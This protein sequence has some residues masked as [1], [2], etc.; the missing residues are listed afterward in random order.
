MERPSSCWGVALRQL[1]PRKELRLE[2][3]TQVAGELDDAPGVLD[4]LDV[5]MPE[6]SS[7][8]QPQLVYMRRAWR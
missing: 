1:Q 2:I 6:T 4:D 5:S 7:K 8:N 3:A